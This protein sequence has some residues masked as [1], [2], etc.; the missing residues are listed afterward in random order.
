MNNKRKKWSPEFKPKAAG[1]L[2]G[3]VGEVLDF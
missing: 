1:I 3:L 2:M